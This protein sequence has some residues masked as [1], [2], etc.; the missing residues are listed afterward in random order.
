VSVPR[1]IEDFYARAWSSLPAQTQLLLLVAAAEPTGE[2]A[3]LWR[4]AAELDISPEAAAPAEAAG[5]MEIDTRVRFRHPLARSAVSRA[6]S[7]PDHRR[8]HGALAAATDPEVDPDRRA[9][10]RAQA[11][12]GTDE[13]VA[14]ELERSADRARARGGSAASGAFLQRAAELSP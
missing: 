13:D 7:P 9:W 10:H 3:L 2:V 11:V 1:R 12:L 8:A 14:A 5:L 4:A 6:A